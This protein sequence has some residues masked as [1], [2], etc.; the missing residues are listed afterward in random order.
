MSTFLSADVAGIIVSSLGIACS[1]DPPMTVGFVGAT[2]TALSAVLLNWHRL[3]AEVKGI[4]DKASRTKREELSLQEILG[5]LFYS[6]P[7][8]CP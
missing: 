5:I 3:L 6:A 4:L 1:D 7:G 8:F 2:G